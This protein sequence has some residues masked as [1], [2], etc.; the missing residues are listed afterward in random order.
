M[1]KAINK[2]KNSLLSKKLAQV[3]MLVLI[4]FGFGLRLIDLTDAPLDFHPTR[5]YRGALIARSI[6]RQM[7]PMEDAAEQ[8][9]AL[10]TRYS[11]AELEPPIFESMVAFGYLALGEEQLWVARILSSLIWLGAGWLIFKITSKF[12]SSGAAL[13][14]LAYFLFLPFAVSASR[15]FQPDPLMVAM[16]A[17]SV[18]FALSWADQSTWKRTIYSAIAAGLAVLIKAVALYY[19]AGLLLVIVL[20][21]MSLKAALRDRQVWAMAGIAIIIPSLYYLPNLLDS[22]GSYVQNWVLALLPIAYDPAFYVRWLNFLGD[23]FGLTTIFLALA[24]T[25]IAQSR[26]RAML[27]GLWIGYLL[28]GITLPHQ[29][30]THNYYHLPLTLIIALSLAPIIQ[31]LVDAI[32]KIERKWQWLFAGLVASAIL[33]NAWTSRSNFLGEDHREEIV[34]WENVGAVLPSDGKIIGLVQHY[35]QLL[36]YYGQRNIALWPVTSEIQLAALRGKS[37]DDFEAAF[38]GRVEGKAYFLVTTFNQLSQQ[39]L[40]ADYLNGHFPIYDEGPGYRIYD[41]RSNLSPDA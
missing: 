2:K 38:L 34:Y 9:L 18:Y 11:V 41:L 40:L 15:S 12:S 29:T 22:G 27:I 1:Q 13:I 3:L 17:L 35:G 30:L 20:S 7:S 32:A 10:V 4:V 6:Y 25:L 14:S 26:Y 39:E 5:Q 31:L 16:I 24:G 37:V 33:F 36:N 28:Y 19:V 23:L 8:A 21:K